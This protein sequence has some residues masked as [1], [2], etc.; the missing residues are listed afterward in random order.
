MLWYIVLL[1]HVVTVVPTPAAAAV[2]A[3]GCWIG[4]RFLASHE[5]NQPQ[6]VRFPFLLCLYFY[7]IPT[8][9]SPPHLACLAN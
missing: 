1:S 4:T 8:V 5:A 9:K 7:F 6:G 2:G 3:Q